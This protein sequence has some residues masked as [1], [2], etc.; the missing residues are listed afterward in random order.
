MP[1][2]LPGEHEPWP[3]RLR[4]P[5]S[6][7]HLRV[8]L[9]DAA[10]AQHDDRRA[11][12]PR[13]IAPSEARFLIPDAPARLLRALSRGDVLLV[14]ASNPLPLVGFDAAHRPAPRDLD[15]GSPLQGE[16]PSNDAPEQ[17]TDEESLHTIEVLVVDARGEPQSGILYELVLPD[18]STRTGRTGADGHLR[19]GGLTQAGDCRITFPEVA[20]PPEV[21]A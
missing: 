19:L 5:G 8:E 21:S 2:R 7:V 13:H 4:I 12:T 3:G 10:L 14:V 9:V 15:D 20:S 17:V 6:N 18:G 11:A 1:L 16:E